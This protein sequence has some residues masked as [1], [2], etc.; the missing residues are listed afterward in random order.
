MKYLQTV[1][2]PKLPLHIDEEFTDDQAHLQGL[3]HGTTSQFKINM[4][5]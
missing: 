2:F 3:S 4:K 5:L 1:F